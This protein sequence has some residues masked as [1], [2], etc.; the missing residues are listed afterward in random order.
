MS[1]WTN[2]EDDFMGGGSKYPNLA[3]PNRGDTALGIV[4]RV[5]KR[6]DSTPDGTLKTWKNGD[7]MFVYI[8]EMR[9]PGSGEV[10]NLWVRGNMVTAIREAV[11]EAGKSSPLG[12]LLRVQYHADGEPTQRGYAPPK[13]FRARCEPAPANA[14]PRREPDPAPSAPKDDGGWGSAPPAPQPS[15]QGAWGDEEPF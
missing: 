7:P 10:S 6:Q 11:R 1:D 9:D 3:F 5:D 8:F 12:T 4:D 13:L 15:S 2:P 14:A